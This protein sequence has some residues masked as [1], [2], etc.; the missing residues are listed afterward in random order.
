MKG[1]SI[2]TSQAKKAIKKLARQKGISVW[3]VRAEI[4]FAIERGMASPNPAVQ[5]RWARIP[6]KWERPTSEEVIAFMAEQAI[7][8]P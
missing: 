1:I 6:K 4:E 5:A 3:K 8:R 2:N 7:N